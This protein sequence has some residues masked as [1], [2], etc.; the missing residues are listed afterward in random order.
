[1]SV[2]LKISK[3]W[4]LFNYSRYLDKI[5]S[6]LI[7]IIQHEQYF[8]LFQTHV[9]AVISCSSPISHHQVNNKCNRV[10]ARHWRWLIYALSN[11]LC[12]NVTCFQKQ[13]PLFLKVSQIPHEN[14]CVGVSFL[15]SCRPASLFHVCFSLHLIIHVNYIKSY[16]LYK[17]FNG[18]SVTDLWK[19]QRKKTH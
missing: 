13:P 3:F 9:S 10:K 4:K 8:F 14:T 16:C 12:Y 7:N 17:H 2:C 1:M 5:V 6:I 11:F 19:H 18:F 15:K